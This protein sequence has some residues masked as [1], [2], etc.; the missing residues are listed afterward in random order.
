[1]PA[2]TPRAVVRRINDEFNRA[3]ADATLRERFLDVGIEPQGGSD[4]KFAAY[5]ATEFP[6]WAKVARD[7]NIGME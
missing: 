7:A 1:V 2:K 6:K 5:L 4:E 3:L